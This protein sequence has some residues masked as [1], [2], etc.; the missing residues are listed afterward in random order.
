MDVVTKVSVNVM[1][2]MKV[3]TAL[4]ESAQKNV[5]ATA[6][7]LLIWHVN[8]TKASWVLIAQPK[9]AHVTVLEEVCAIM[10]HVSATENGLA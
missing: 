4:A 7:A 6:F 10:V 9:L 2:T 5:Q 1:M 8:A 3:K